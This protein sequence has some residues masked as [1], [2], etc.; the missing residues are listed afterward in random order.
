[1]GQYQEADMEGI[2]VNQYA[3]VLYVAM[4]I[5]TSIILLNL[6]VAIM[7]DMYEEVERNAQ[8]Q[9]RREQA[10][11]L[12]DNEH[13]LDKD[14]IKRKFEP[15]FLYELRVK[16]PFMD[17]E[18]VVLVQEDKS[19]AQVSSDDIAKILKRLE[20]SLGEVANQ[21]RSVKDQSDETNL[22][23]KE[24]EKVCNMTNNADRRNSIFGNIGLRKP[25]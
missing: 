15:L 13:H 7:G 11:I 5:V 23:V 14:L 16:K 21:M 24:L 12:T 10:A 9:F 20:S 18:D 6:L 4:V 8:A 19:A 1:M 2:Q 22:L 3:R 25:K 17:E